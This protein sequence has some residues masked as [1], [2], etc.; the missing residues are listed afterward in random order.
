MDR[1]DTSSRFLPD[2]NRDADRIVVEI[3][4]TSTSFSAERLPSPLDPMG[5][6]YLRGRM[7][8]GI[9]GGRIPWWVLI[10]SWVILGGFALA[11]FAVT[12]LGGYSIFSFIVPF[13]IFFVLIKG[14]IAKIS[15]T[16]AR[17]RR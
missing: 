6:I 5:E 11:F 12:I 3:P 4:S 8:R 1:G 7:F 17:R 13:F 9:S 15:A 10:S 16:K 2:D 14:T